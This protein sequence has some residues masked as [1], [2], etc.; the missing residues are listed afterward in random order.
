V[1]DTIREYGFK[2][3]IEIVPLGN[4]FCET[5]HVDL[6]KEQ[7]R[8]ELKISTN[9]TTFLFVGQLIWEKNIRMI[10]ESLALIKDIPFKM[11]FV[12]IGYA[13]EDLKQLVSKMGLSDKIEFIGLITDRDRLKQFY[14]AADLFLFPS[15]YDTWALVVREAAALRTPSVLVQ[16]SNVA[17]IITDNVNGFLVENSI[18]SLAT[19]LRRLI[20]NPELVKQVGINASKSITRSWESVTDEVL[21]RY[22]HLMKRI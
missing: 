20:S 11:F 5:Q 6:I 2:G 3:K 17:R 21:D 10:L 18:E 8:K 16:E 1:E 15:T 19:C 13:A 7:A 12:G 22:N 9:E 4:D 14:A